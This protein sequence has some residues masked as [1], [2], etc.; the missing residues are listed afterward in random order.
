MDLKINSKLP[1]PLVVQDNSKD[2]NGKEIPSFW[3]N[4]QRW[5]EIDQ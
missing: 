4:G 5:L 2:A 3:Y 1:C